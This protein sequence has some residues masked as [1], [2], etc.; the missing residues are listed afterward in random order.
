M[1]APRSRLTS[2]SLCL[3]VATAVRAVPGAGQAAPSGGDTASSTTLPIPIGARVRAL[4]PAPG[5][6][7][8]WLVGTALAVGRDEVRIREDGTGM[9]WT[10]PVTGARIEISRGMN[11]A[12]HG[13]VAGAIGGFVLGEV[14]GV[15]LVKPSHGVGPDPGTH[16]G[17]LLFDPAVLM[18]A[19]AGTVGGI[20]VGRRLRGER[21]EPV[22]PDDA[23]LA[24]TNRGVVVRVAWRR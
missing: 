6:R 18:V 22:I 21:W 10:V 19:A 7:D 14:A 12:R 1:R 23:W 17:K 3:L 4:V 11:T 2:L 24:P 5:R 15:V 16:I 9:P 8:G 13:A 20:V